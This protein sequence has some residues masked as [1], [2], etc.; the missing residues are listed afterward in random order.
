MDKLWKGIK[1]WANKARLV[2]LFKIEWK[3]PHHNI[4]VEF[5]NNCKL[6]HEHNKIKVMLGDEERIIDKHVLVEVFRI[7]HTIETEE[8]QVEMSDVKVAMAY[9][10]NR[11]LDTYNTNEGWVVKKMKSEYANRIVA[12]LPIIYQK[13]KV[14][15]FS[16]KSAMMISRADH[17]ESINWAIIMFS[18]L[19]KE[20]IRWEKCQKNMI[21]GITKR[22]PK[23][24]VCHSAIILKFMF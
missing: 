22:E 18:Q 12:I 11:V 9:I 20:L 5:L 21:E 6:D 7:C 3:T 13:D 4:L 19:V 15:Y 17:G 1:T 2:G 23:K 10:T 16:N 14:Q 24:D 8:D